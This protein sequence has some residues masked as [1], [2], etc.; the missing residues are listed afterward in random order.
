MPEPVTKKYLDA[1]LAAIRRDIRGLI[2]P[3]KQGPAEHKQRLKR[4]SALVDRR[5]DRVDER[6]NK[7]N[8]KIDVINK[9]LAAR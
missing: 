4:R 8:A 9:K 6:L 3:I 2:R 7:L 5:F 1:A